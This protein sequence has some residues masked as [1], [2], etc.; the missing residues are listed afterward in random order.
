MASEGIAIVGL[1][2]LFPGAH[3]PEAFWRSLMDETDCTSTAG[4]A[5]LGAEPGVLFA[6]QP[7]VPDKTYWLRGGYVRDVQL[8]PHGFAAAPEVVSALDEPSRWALYVAREALRDAHGPPIDLTGCGLVLGNLSFPTK[9]SRRAYGEIYAASVEAALQELLQRSEIRL[10][11]LSQS[12]P[13]GFQDTVATGSS[14]GSVAAL[15]G[16]AGPCF[17]LDAACA[18]SLYA[19]KLAADYLLAH[20]ANLMLAG[21]VSCADPLFIT[22]GFARFRAYPD[23]SSASRPLDQS[24]RG[25]MSGEGAGMFVLEREQD[26]LRNGH[27]VYALLR[28]VGLSSDGR[29]KHLLTPNSKGQ[30]LALRRAYAEAGIQPAGVDYVECHATGTPIGDV[31]ELDSMSEVF[32]EAPPPLG[33]VKSNLGHLLTA[34]GMAGM[35]KAIL[36]M[37]NGLVPAT[38]GIGDP[39]VSRDGRLGGQH[40]VRSATRWPA[41]G[42]VKRAGVSAFGFGGVN[43]HLVLEGPGGPS[44]DTSATPV[45]RVELA[46]TGLGAHFGGCSDLASLSRSLFDGDRQFRELPRERWK[47]I[48]DQSNVLAALGL[49]GPPRGAYIASF[50][51]DFLRFGIPPQEDGGPISQQLLLL[52]V[53]DEAIRDAG[54]AEGGNVAVVVAMGAELELHRYCGRVDLGWQIS[55]ALAEAG[56]HLTPLEYADLETLARNAVLEGASV[57]QY[58]SFIGNIMASR[59]AAQWDFSGPAFTV[60]AGDN[61][62]FYALDVAQLL[63]S[64]DQV[65]AVVLAGV[66]LAGSVESV[67][68]RRRGGAVCSGPETMS[69]DRGAQGWPVGEGAGALVLLPA[70]RAAESGARVYAT[71]DALRIERIAAADGG[72]KALALAAERA[73]LAAGRQPADVGYLELNASGLPDED[74]AEIAALASVY[75]APDEAEP[76]CALGSVKALLGHAGAAA[77]IAA[78]IR[79]ALCLHERYIP[80][81]PGWQAP[82]A[83][84]AWERAGWYVAGDSRPWLSLEN[85]R[86]AAAVSGLGDGAAAHVIMSAAGSLAGSATPGKDGALRQVSPYL[87]QGPAQLFLAGGHDRASLLAALDDLGTRAHDGQSLDLLAV[88]SAIQPGAGPLK[89]ALVAGNHDLL[90]KE[91][92]RAQSGV[93]AA[94]AAG[95]EWSTPAGS[96]FTASPLAGTGKIAFVYSGG[97]SSYVGLGRRLQHAFPF[98]HDRLAALAPDSGLVVGDRLLYPRTVAALGTQELLAHESRLVDDAFAVAASSSTFSLQTTLLLREVFGVQPDAAFGFSLGEASMMIALGVWHVP[99]VVRQATSASEALRPRMCG[100]KHAVREFWGTPA[101]V[102]D[103]ELWASY[104]VLAPPEDVQHALDGE[105]CAY[106]TIVGAPREVFLCG[107]PLACQRVIQRVGAGSAPAP[108]NYVLH[109]P[110]ARSEA[111]A[112]AAMYRLE[113]VRRPPV[114]FYSAAGYEPL[115][116]ESEDIASAI[117]A[118]VCLPLDF[119]RLVRR[120]Y[121]DGARIFVEL[122]PGS[123]CARWIRAALSDE[124]HLA[125]S[126]DQKGVDER[127]SIVRALAKLISHGVKLNLQPLFEPAEATLVP[128]TRG[129]HVQRV[130]LGDGRLRDSIVTEEN[131]LRFRVARPAEALQEA[132]TERLPVRVE[133]TPPSMPSPRTGAGHATAG[134]PDYLGD[135]AAA[136]GSNSLAAAHSTFLQSQ[137]Q[138]ALALGGLVDRHIRIVRERLGDWAKSRPEPAR[139]MAIWDE[140]A[141]LEFAGGNIAAVFGPEYGVI[142]SY[143]RRV[144]LPLPPYLLVS[145]VTRLNARRGVFEPSTMTTEYDI[146]RGSWYSVDGQIPWAV[147]VESGQCD[148][149][150]I[151]YLGIDFENRGERVYRLLDCALTFLEPVPLE[152]QTL[153]YDIS[154]NS[155]AR[156]GDDLLFFFSYDCFVADKLVLRMDG[157]CAGFFSDEELRRGRGVVFSE[158]ELQARAA[159]V[160]R[161]FHPLLPCTRRSFGEEDMERLSDGNLRAV[162]GA[163]HDQHE[164]NQSL[165]LPPRAIGMFDRVISV[166]PEAG[167]W[168][169]GVLL[170]EKD[171]APDQ[172]YF[173]SH[174]KDDE[175]LAGSLMAEGCVQ[176]LQLYLLFLGVHVRTRGGRFEPIAGLRQVVRCRGQVTPEHRLLTYRMEITD[177]GLTPEPYAIA[178]VEIWVGG[179]MVVHFKDLGLRIVDDVA[180]LPEPAASDSSSADEQ[181]IREF[182]TGSVAACFG[183]EFSIYEG[184]TTPRQPNGDLQLISRIVTVEGLRLDFNSPARVVAEYDVPAEPWFYT[185]SVCQEVPYSI[186]MELALQPCGFLS[187]W[188]GSTLMFPD[189]ELHFRN[190]DGRGE[191]LSKPNL[192]GKTIGNHVRITS[193]VAMQSIVIQK[194]EFEL[195]CEGDV[196]YRGDAA[197]GYFSNEAL[198]NQVGLDGG[199]AVPPWIDGRRNGAFEFDADAQAGHFDLLDRFAIVDKGGRYGRGYVFAEKRVDPFDWFFANHFYQDPVMPGSL[200]VEAMVQA[201]QAYARVTRKGAGL[202]SPRLVQPAPHTTVWKYRGQIVPTHER[203]TLEMHVKRLDRSSDGTATVI[204]ADGSLW[205]DSL[206]IY[207]VTDLALLVGDADQGPA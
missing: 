12:S 201:L 206:R 102:S 52:S 73:L 68:Q 60:S 65:D 123:T 42:D 172:W 95:G 170:A 3:T 28:G 40:V 187:A 178:N 90:L 108:F 10:P 128:A 17:C 176:L 144:R 29:G 124:P 24:S 132:G 47:G 99:A 33:S 46:I 9:A 62:G 106:L 32:G 188:L 48:E 182:A 195:Q 200:G 116:L 74:D 207:E 103:A 56:V 133:V 181:H 44:R 193:S 114:R 93:L 43:A 118:T 204:V 91:I 15:L 104:I 129:A 109:C 163:G 80:G 135:S 63:L 112:L 79:T 202:D 141:L 168:G 167:P 72:S 97:I 113:V 199:A 156:S 175:V 138:G 4:A 49:D 136:L 18:S 139:R 37:A 41:R 23:G 5:E 64:R 159:A 194:F 171:L 160:P 55:A 6:P 165:R 177:F 27:R 88:T 89:V 180:A 58:V 83:P 196:F 53:A 22:M 54:L 126:V 77:G 59:V 185:E 162:F 38:R 35:T 183:P 101:A 117:S 39:V 153:R 96:Y 151:S 19:V 66:D 82:K 70:A 110:V 87:R 92:E 51:F 137:H 16:L 127:T 125:L 205:R 150:L 142:D 86:R 152:G 164:R 158:A 161:R 191:L 2:C 71:I 145:R 189:E 61:A 67:L 30:V 81:T 134:S 85:K 143:R 186:L 100:P 76:A 50:E 115:N 155:F 149:L 174:F 14:A 131:I 148:L 98:L 84:G 25:L 107:D 1:G 8:D 173:T 11:R 120:V 184:R 166:E 197:F 94:L 119:P 31:V 130:V 140:D 111:D 105:D 146:P 179:K 34:A 26:A 36:A 7:G 121:E 75:G 147:A 57:N 190:L 21:A 169:L 192:R 20:E 45:T 78:L 154:I 203:M 13:G 122:G 157:G 198:A 69:H